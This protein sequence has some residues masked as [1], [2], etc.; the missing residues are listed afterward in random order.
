MNLKC[1]HL[2]IIRP[3]FVRMWSLS[4]G[5]HALLL[6]WTDGCL[7]FWLRFKSA[8]L[9]SLTGRFGR[10]QGAELRSDRTHRSAGRLTGR[11]SSCCCR[12]DSTRAIIARRASVARILKN[13]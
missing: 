1:L 8:P 11:K 9:S 6:P 13:S 3:K 7:Q 5:Q 4:Y 2:Y 10:P 12:R